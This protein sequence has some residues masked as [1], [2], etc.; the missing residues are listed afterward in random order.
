LK[1]RAYKAFRIDV[2]LQT[3]HSDSREGLN[4]P[5]SKESSPQKRKKEKKREKPFFVFT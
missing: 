4:Q 2:P 3:I 5:D 1:N